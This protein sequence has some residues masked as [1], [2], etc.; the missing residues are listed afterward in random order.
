MIKD[1]NRKQNIF[2]LTKMLLKINYKLSN[3]FDFI[4]H[5]KGINELKCI[6]Q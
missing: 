5:Q 1:T 2:L 6:T 3:D 4:L